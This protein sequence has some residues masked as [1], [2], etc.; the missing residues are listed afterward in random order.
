MKPAYNPNGYCYNTFSPPPPCTYQQVVPT[1]KLIEVE[2]HN[3][4]YE[5]V[6]GRSSHK[7][8]PHESPSNELYKTKNNNEITNNIIDVPSDKK[9]SQLE[10]WD[11]VY[12][13]L[14]SQGYSK[15]LGERGDLLCSNL[16]KNAKETKKV[17]ST[18]LD[19][20]LN[21]LAVNDKP[22]KSNESFNRKSVNKNKYDEL[23]P[24]DKENSSASSYDNV[25]TEDIRKQNKPTTANNVRLKVPQKCSNL[26][27]KVIQNKDEKPSKK[28]QNI[29]NP[30]DLNKWQ[31]KT[32]TFLNDPKNDICDICCKSKAV[33]S[34]PTMEIG[35]A[36][37]PKCTL[38][39][40]KHL[41]ACEACGE[42]LENSPTYI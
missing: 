5:V 31:C 21:N 40:P 38:V 18:N 41:K 2:S 13:N 7:S 25:H 28:K 34:E 33:T 1:G 12:R 22:V 27:D 36:E 4:S 15:D 26:D 29:P 14:E 11:Y 39:N 16:L 3:G 35:G 24:I 10:D 19:E 42:N 30:V 6:D 32:C 17:K 23:G 37:C 9:D 20:H 8:R